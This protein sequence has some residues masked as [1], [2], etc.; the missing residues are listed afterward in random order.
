VSVN[1]SIREPRPTVPLAAGLLMAGF[2][3]ASIWHSYLLF[4]SLVEIFSVVIA[5]GVFM[6][7]WNSRGHP[8]SGL[9]LILGIGFLFTG[10]VDI[11]HMLAY[12]GMG[13]FP[14][15]MDLATKLWVAGR[16]LKALAFLL[17][18]ISITWRVRLA[19]PLLTAVFAVLTVLFL[20]SILYWNFFPVCF[21][22]GEGVTAFKRVSE[23]AVSAVFALSLALL[24]R[25]RARFDPPAYRR[26]AG[27]LAF[28][29]ASEIAFTL[30]LRTTGIANLIGHL[31]KV[32]AYSLVYS[33]LIAEQ[34]RK[35][36]LEIR[37]LEQAQGTLQEQEKALREANATKDKFFSI[38]AHD[39]RNPLA[40]MRTVTE[41][42]ESRYDRLNDEERR[43]F[44][45][46]LH[47]GTGQ[48]MDLMQSLLWWARSQAGRMQFNPRKLSLYS[49]VEENIG[50][51][52]QAAG[53]KQID[54]SSSIPQEL[55]VMADPEM[56]STILRNLLSNAVKFTPRGG[57][58]EVSALEDGAEVRVSMADTGVGMSAEEL[59]KLFRIDE[60]LSRRGTDQEPGNGLGLLVCR[61]F[62]EKHGGRIWAESRPGEGSTFHFTLPKAVAAAP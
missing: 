24:I 25:G 4:H 18:A 61:E 53:Q 26:L 54:I 32:V 19:Y 2:L 48:A 57:G 16:Y 43:K 38:I 51:M 11:F 15:G 47:E 33:S 20:G 12:Q 22:E 37:Q 50:L 62:V 7:A 17:F 52:R 1:E 21:V 36:I 55:Q 42:L 31:F 56:A 6:I 41:L 34:V 23:Y 28:S 30:Y 13:V 59:Q 46:L 39:M 29:I 5:G 14:S 10:I 58:L 9:L 44:C 60:H 45:H 49:L 35:R 3:L 27:A 8:D 40:G